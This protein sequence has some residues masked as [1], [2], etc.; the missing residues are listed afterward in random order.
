M[1]HFF[2]SM[3]IAASVF[4]MAGL[5][6]CSNEN[7]PGM[8]PPEGEKGI[9]TAMSLTLNMK[10]IQTRASEGAAGLDV[11][12]FTTTDE[13]ALKTLHVYIYD[14]ASGLLDQNH[15]LT[16][17]DG[18]EG[19][20]IKDNKDGTYTTKALTA[21][22]GDKKVYVG[23]NLTTAMT[24]VLAK[25]SLNTLKTSAVTETL[26]EMI[27]TNTG[28][29]M[30]S[31]TAT[32]GKFEESQDAT[33]VPTNNKVKANVERMVAKIGVGAKTAPQKL[34]ADGELKDLKW[35]VD[36]I[37]KKFYMP[38]TKTDPS[39]T[40]D[41]W[42]Q[43][44]FVNYDFNGDDKPADLD[45]TLLDVVEGA[46]STWKTSYST[47]NFV[48]DNKL[49]GMTRVVVKGTYT[50]AQ[51]ITYTLAA[52]GT[53]TK[54]VNAL[55]AGTTYYQVVIPGDDKFVFLAAEPD[56]TALTAYYK[57]VTKQDMP[58][59]AKT[60]DFVKKYTNGDNYWWVT[61]KETGSDGNVERNHV[62]LANI[63]SISLPG[64]TEGEFTDKDENEEL[65]KETNI[66][67]TVTVL[68]W[69]LVAFDTDLKP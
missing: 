69:Y 37:G 18:T 58:A 27:S 67:I 40:A 42:L 31:P 7:D 39:M 49:K 55:T 24:N 11:K 26:T 59:D 25:S 48:N 17:T 54:A 12:D 1:K 50:P 34:G 66:D 30:F 4:T 45:P 32:D 68:D 22:T 2:S 62:Y 65:D 36:N 43:A 13:T 16:Y 63:N 46:Q 51:D 29:S 6:S 33:T 28:F 38:A 9:P 20:E 5:T 44:D 14:A 56:A 15:K 35:A 10:G 53:L 41:A 61:M 21:F 23:L 57:I 52:D 64:R 19:S 47:E 60:E 8:T 3:F